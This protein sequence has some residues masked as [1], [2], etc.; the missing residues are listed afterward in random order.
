MDDVITEYQDVLANGEYISSLIL[1]GDDY[2]LLVIT[3]VELILYNHDVNY[4]LILCNNI[5]H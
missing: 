2:S 5:I 1:L 3:P 4:I